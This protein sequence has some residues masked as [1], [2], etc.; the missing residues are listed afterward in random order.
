MK[1][2]SLADQTVSKIC[3]GVSQSFTQEVRPQSAG[4]P[5][6]KIPLYGTLSLIYSQLT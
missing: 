1:R 3:V 5:I 4:W 6:S 2:T